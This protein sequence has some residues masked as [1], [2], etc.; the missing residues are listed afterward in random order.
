MPVVEAGK[1]QPLRQILLAGVVVP[2]VLTEQAVKAS[3]PQPQPE[4]QA[5]RVTLLL[6]EPAL[7]VQLQ[8][9]ILVMAILGPS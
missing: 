9:P 8:S 6:V 5:D 4:R 7:P 1:S 3:M 2:P